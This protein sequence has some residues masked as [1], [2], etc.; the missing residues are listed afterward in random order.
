M[1]TL[2]IIPAYNEQANI[3]KTV[4][5]LSD[6]LQNCDYLII[7]DCSTDKTADILDANGYPHIDLPVN[8]GL[9][10]AVQAGY[11]YAYENGY[12]CAVQFDGDGQHQAKYIEDMSKQIEDGFD[13]V[14]GSRFVSEK[15]GFSLRMIGSRIITGLIFLKTGK[16]ITDPTSGMRM[17]NRHMLFDYAY[18]MNR[19]PEPDTLVVQLRHKAKIKEIQVYMKDREGGTSMYNQLWPSVKYMVSII[20]SIIFLS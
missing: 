9:S 5:D 3:V 8:L 7:N 13:I 15:K 16:T 10:G 12:D 6:N 1:K 18:K 20:L 14:I 4:K 17:L 2:V 11:K 19:D